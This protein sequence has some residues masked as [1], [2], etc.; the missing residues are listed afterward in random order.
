MSPTTTTHTTSSVIRNLGF[1]DG[2]IHYN[3]KASDYTHNQPIAS[4][5]PGAP[6][7]SVNC[8]QSLMRYAIPGKPMMATI[9]PTQIKAPPVLLWRIPENS[10]ANTNIGMLKAPT[11]RQKQE[12]ITKRDFKMFFSYWSPKAIYFAL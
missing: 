12:T 7:T 1:I 8:L 4:K 5:I 11:H 10:V 9:K 3:E 6:V 2:S